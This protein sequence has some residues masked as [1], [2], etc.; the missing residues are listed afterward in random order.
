MSPVPW[1]ALCYR[2]LEELGKETVMRTA[3]AILGAAYIGA[4]GVVIVA[5]GRAAKRGD[6]AKD[7][8]YAAY[9]QQQPQH[10]A[11]GVRTGQSASQGQV[12]VPRSGNNVRVMQEH[13]P[14]STRLHSAWH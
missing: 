13:R 3:L 1:L 4:G 8:A 2:C 10:A 7:E 11:G 6:E 14:N 9:L 12:R 5:L